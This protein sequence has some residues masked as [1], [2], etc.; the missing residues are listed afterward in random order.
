MHQLICEMVKEDIIGKI[1]E[2]L[3]NVVENEEA[4]VSEEI[5]GEE[6][7]EKRY[8]VIEYQSQEMVEKIEYIKKKI[9]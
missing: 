3:Q 4:I 9:N 7:Q 1:R 8:R 5:E 6:E 2:R